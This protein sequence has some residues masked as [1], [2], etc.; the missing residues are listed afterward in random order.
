MDWAIAGPIIGT[1]IGGFLVGAKD[2][3]TQR[4]QRDA[5][6]EERKEAR[7]DE[8]FR[9]LRQA[10]ADLV[11]VQ[12]KVFDRALYVLNARIHLDDHLQRTSRAQMQASYGA[13]QKEHA[14]EMEQT[15]QQLSARL[16]QYMTDFN[17]AMTEKQ[18]KAVAVLLLEEAPAFQRQV[19]QVI[20]DALPLPQ[21][22]TQAE[23]VRFQTD[24]QTQQGRLAELIRSLSGR[25]SLTSWHEAPPTAAAPKEP[26]PKSS[27]ESA[28]EAK[29]INA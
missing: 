29:S 18:T 8:H 14:R 26:T 15:G 13:D 17:A 3:L 2:W 1:V 27:Q 24:I 25:F 5:K 23:Y 9:N 19:E 28:D 11:T 22:S 21:A 16:Q 7:R 6:R 4:T 10:Y 20:R 12:A